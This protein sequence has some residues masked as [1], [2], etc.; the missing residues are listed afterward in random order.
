MPK[1]ILVVSDEQ[2]DLWVEAAHAQRLS[3]SEWIRR[4]CDGGLAAG[5]PG[6]AAAPRR[7]GSSGFESQS[8]APTSPAPAASP[9]E[10]E[11][12]P[13]DQAKAIEVM[14]EA[15]YTLP[16]P[17][18]ARS[19]PQFRADPK[20]KAAQEHAPKERQRA[21]RSMCEHRVPAGQYCKRC[22]A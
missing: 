7:E 8:A 3:L 5:E 4:R 21:S 20:Q 11:P 19:M 1:V 16:D 12:D 15:G 17:P 22:A 10:L 18:P 9:T 2:K 6:G 14:R 13:L